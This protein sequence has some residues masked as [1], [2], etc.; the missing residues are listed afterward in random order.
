ML[1]Y[2]CL[3][4]QK[5]LFLIVVSALYAPMSPVS[6]AFIVIILKTGLIENN[7]DINY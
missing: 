6:L 3:S 4:W 2:S 5:D 7:V 1:A